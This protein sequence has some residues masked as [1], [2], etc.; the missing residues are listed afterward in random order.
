V[1]GR[2]TLALGRCGFVETL[3][4][5]E[6]VEVCEGCAEANVAIV[7]HVVQAL[8]SLILTLAAVSRQQRTERVPVCVGEAIF[9]RVGVENVGEGVGREGAELRLELRW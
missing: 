9:P 3:S 4:G 6:A 1:G 8:H 5:E 7:E 2:K